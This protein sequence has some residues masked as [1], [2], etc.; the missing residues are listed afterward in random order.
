MTTRVGLS[1][2][3]SLWLNMDTVEN[4]MIIESITAFYLC[5]GVRSEQG[6]SFGIVSFQ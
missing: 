4:L 2:N 5:D 1:P 3:D 6:T